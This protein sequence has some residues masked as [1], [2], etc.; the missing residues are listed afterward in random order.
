L[1]ELGVHVSLSKGTKLPSLF[2]VGRALA[3]EQS[4]AVMA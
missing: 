4:Q 2:P 1:K 3:D